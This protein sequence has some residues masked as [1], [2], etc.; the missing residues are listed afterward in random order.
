MF[1][2]SFP[3]TIWGPSK[4][5]SYDRAVKLLDFIALFLEEL[6]QSRVYIRRVAAVRARPRCVL[7]CESTSRCPPSNND[8]IPPL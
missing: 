4:E 6:R 2:P 3:Q 1:F 7:R 5:K 8:L